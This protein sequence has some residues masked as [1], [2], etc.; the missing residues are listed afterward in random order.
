MITG[1]RLNEVM[2]AQYQRQ[3]DLNV[4]EDLE[5]DKTTNLSGDLDRAD[6]TSLCYLSV[7]V[8]GNRTF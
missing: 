6:F 2:T 3:K 5:K 1:M 8:E 4:V 7:V